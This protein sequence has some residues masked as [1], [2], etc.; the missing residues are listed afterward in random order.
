MRI[1]GVVLAAGAGSRLGQPKGELIVDGRRLVDRAWSVL[2]EA[3]CA[4][5]FAVVRAG[6]HVGGAVV[7][8]QPERGLRSSLELGVTAAGDAD[9]VAVLLADLPGVS[10]GAAVSAIAAWRPGRIAVATYDGVRGHPIVMSPGL[11][12][13]AITLAAPDEGARALLRA[14]ADLVDEVAVEGDPADLDTP[15]DLDAWLRATEP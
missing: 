7:N 8:P 1:A 3:G 9:A 12:R 10:A 13:E 11:W 5:V 14:R 4:P 6:V 2:H 15:A